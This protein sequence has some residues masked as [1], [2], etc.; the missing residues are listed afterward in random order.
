[1]ASKVGALATV[2]K[3]QEFVT[4]QQKVSLLKKGNVSVAY[5][6]RGLLRQ[7][8][9]FK[10]IHT[11]HLLLDYLVTLSNLPLILQRE[12]ELFLITVEWHVKNTMTSLESNAVRDKMKTICQKHVT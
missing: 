12:D 4:V 10:F 11:L 7:L 9:D 8:T 1:V 6:Y 3:G 2:M 5:E